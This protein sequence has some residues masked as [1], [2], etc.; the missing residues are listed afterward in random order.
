LALFDLFKK[1]DLIEISMED[2]ERVAKE[3]AQAWEDVIRETTKSYLEQFKQEVKKYI[4]KKLASC[5]KKKKPSRRF[6][7]VRDEYR[8]HPNKEIKLPT[9]ATANSAGYD[10]YSNE[11]IMIPPGSYHVFWT[12]VKVK[13]EKDE[14]LMIVP[15]SSVATQKNLILANSVGIIDADYYNNPDNDGNIGIWLINTSNNQTATI[16]EGE[17]IAQGII[18]KYFASDKTQGKRGGGFGSTGR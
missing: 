11:T 14:F 9:R 16:K 4:D 1:K 3:T 10:F 12:D 7:V 15:R 17:R 8:K 5:K 18:L 6:E 13:L 2:L